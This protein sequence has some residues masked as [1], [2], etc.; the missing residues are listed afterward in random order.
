MKS[1]IKFYHYKV[2]NLK[3][4]INDTKVLNLVAFTLQEV[5]LNFKYFS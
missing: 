2:N 1:Y 4:F 5:K 3:K